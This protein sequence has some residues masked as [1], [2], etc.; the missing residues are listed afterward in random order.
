MRHV[1]RAAAFAILIVALSQPA[2]AQRTETQVAE[3][4]EKAAAEEFKRAKAKP[5]TDSAAL[6]HDS[7]E[8]G[9]NRLV[10]E[11]RT[12]DREISAAEKLI[13]RFAAEMV[14]NGERQ[15]DG[16][17]RLGESSFAAAQKSLCPLYPFC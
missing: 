9:A 4:F 15:S 3:L 7:I 11:K 14:K 12:S 13:R 6:L 1:A 8:Q 16:T 5:S 17:L 10:S 2:R